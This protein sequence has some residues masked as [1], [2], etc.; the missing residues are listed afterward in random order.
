MRRSTCWIWS[1]GRGGCFRVRKHSRSCF[2]VAQN[3]IP[4]VVQL[5]GKH[6]VNLNQSGSYCVAF[7][8]CHQLRAGNGGGV[9]GCRLVRRRECRRRGA[10]CEFELDTV[11]DLCC[12]KRS[13]DSCWIHGGDDR[14]TW[15]IDQWSAFQLSL[16]ASRHLGLASWDFISSS[17]PRHR[18]SRAQ[19]HAR[20][21]RGLLA[22]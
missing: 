16:R 11:S 10:L 20:F 19:S 6:V 2:A 3:A 13:V 1:A 15:R 22:S 18:E 4:R 8:C 17:C 21:A 5:R 12:R 7:R 14:S 9:S